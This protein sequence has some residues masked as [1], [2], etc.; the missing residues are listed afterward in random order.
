L[1]PKSVSKEDVT[2]QRCV[3]LGRVGAAY[4]IKG[5]FHLHPFADDPEGWQHVPTWWISPVEPDAE[6]LAPWRAVVPESLRVHG[7]GLVV[8]LTH[9]DDR[10]ES[11][12]LRGYWIGAPR[13]SLPETDSDEYYWADLLG[14]TVVNAQGDTLGQVDRM[15]ETGANA[16]L[17]VLDAS[18]EQ[19]RERLI[20]FVGDI[21]RNVDK[22]AGQILVDWAADW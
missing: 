14:L 13:E 11:E 15:I 3:I 16:V 19:P 18:G 20:P 17:I 1:Q 12:A 22:A 8:K 6:G 9:I 10:N 4:G 21:V 2:Q 7:D 5:W